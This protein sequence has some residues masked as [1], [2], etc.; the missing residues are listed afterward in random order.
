MTTTALVRNAETMQ[1]YLKM[2]AEAFTND[3]HR[4]SPTSDYEISYDF[5][6]KYIKIIKKWGGGQT[7][8]CGFI[9]NCH[10]DKQFAYGDLLKASSWK[11]PA[12]NKARG[13]IF[14]IEGKKFSW[15]GIQ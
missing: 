7:S 1:P 13:N 15:T 5:G 12:K 8:V 11:A 2:L 3:Y 6:N 9:V 4:G 10:N 14:E